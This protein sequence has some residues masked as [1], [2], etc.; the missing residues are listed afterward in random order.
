MTWALAHAPR[1]PSGDPPTETDAGALDLY[2][3][4]SKN[5]LKGAGR[6]VR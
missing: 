5:T 4:S 2:E 1:A 6:G 3:R